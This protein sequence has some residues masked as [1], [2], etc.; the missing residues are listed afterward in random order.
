MH[1]HS[2][3]PHLHRTSNPL[4]DG[5]APAFPHHPPPA[6]PTAHIPFLHIKSSPLQ[7]E[8]KPAAAG[9]TDPSI[10]KAKKGKIANK[11]VKGATQWEIMTKSGLRPE[12]IPAFSDPVHWLHYFPPLG[13]RD[14]L[15][16][17]CGVDWRRSFITTDVNPYYDTFVRWQF[18]TLR[19]NGKIVR[20]K[21]Y[22]VFSPLDKQ[23]C[24]DHDRATGEGVGPQ[25]YTLIKARRRIPT[26][27]LS[28]ARLSA[29]RICA[30]RKPSTR[31]DAQR[32]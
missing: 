1:A 5:T 30:A 16:M 11:A 3:P 12:E 15:A 4:P 28:A 17:G 24:A 2:R 27:R 23:P 22:S 21:R 10:F 32:L 6:P 8:E 31:S 20:A 13:K 25:E 18:N 29:A 7:E 19:R 14:V 9:E 26:A